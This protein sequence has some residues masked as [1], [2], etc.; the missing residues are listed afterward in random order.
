MDSSS[1]AKL[2]S[3]TN[4]QLNIYISLLSPNNIMPGSGNLYPKKA[5]RG[6]GCKGFVLLIDINA[7]DHA[8]ITG[9]TRSPVISANLSCDTV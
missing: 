7:E 6:L 5:G 2:A 4:S 8:G 3:L 9:G 1:H